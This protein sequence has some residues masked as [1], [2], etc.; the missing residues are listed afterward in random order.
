MTA[1]PVPGSATT[2]PSG[3]TLVLRRR[4]FRTLTM[5]GLMSLTLPIFFGTVFLRFGTIPT[6]LVVLVLAMAVPSLIAFALAATLA[7]TWTFHVDNRGV[8]S[9]HGRKQVASLPWASVL[10]V[11]HGVAH[12]A[13]RRKRY[14]ETFLFVVDR[15]GH[16]VLVSNLRHDIPRGT[17]LAATAA[18]ERFAREHGATVFACEI[19]DRSLWQRLPA[20]GRTA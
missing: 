11:Q 20:L 19:L 12:V 2:D 3:Y 9:T 4:E 1:R 6:A 13:I 5:V 18:T 15:E 14:R 8:T 16:G 17:V 7:R 10:A